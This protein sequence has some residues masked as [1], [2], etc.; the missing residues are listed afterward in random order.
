MNNCK[1]NSNELGVIAK[2]EFRE[3]YDYLSYEEV[4]DIYNQALNTYLD[5]TF[6][7]NYSIT[8]IPADRPRAIYWIKDCMKE[9]IDRNGITATSYKENGLSITWSTD[10]VSN[11]LRARIIPVVG[12]RSY[13]R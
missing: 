5:L 6:P 2:A 8:D 13:K 3:K 4:D 10:M 12:F 7:F 1:C 11:I 9:I